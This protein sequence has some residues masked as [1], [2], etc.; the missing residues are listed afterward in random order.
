M[1]EKIEG[2]A[3]FPAEQAVHPN[4]GVCLG[5]KTKQH[6]RNVSKTNLLQNHCRLQLCADRHRCRAQQLALQEGL[7]RT[8]LS[9]ASLLARRVAELSCCFL[10]ARSEAVQ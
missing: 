6:N 9:P 1:E 5:K 8:L 7:A 2:F 4:A 10:L 3:G